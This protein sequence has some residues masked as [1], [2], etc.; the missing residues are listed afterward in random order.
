MEHVYKISVEELAYLTI[1]IPDL[2]AYVKEGK[3]IA[4]VIHYHEAGD[5]D[6]SMR[7]I[8]VPRTVN[9]QNVV[10][11]LTDTCGGIL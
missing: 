5:T 4:L 6:L 2:R 3:D 7:S 9:E 1:E 8:L 11:H 10:L